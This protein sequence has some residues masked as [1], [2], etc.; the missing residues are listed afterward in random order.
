MNQKYN[1]KKITKWGF[2]GFKLNLRR[3]SHPDYLMRSILT[4]LVFLPFTMYQLISLIR[5][6][7]IQIIN[8]HYSLDYFIY[9]AICQWIVLSRWLLHFMELISSQTRDQGRDI[10]VQLNLS[11]SQINGFS[12]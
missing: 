11:Y 2:S 4:F 9:F 10:R 7:Q 5:R 8:I 1:L 12:F 3:P 6:Q